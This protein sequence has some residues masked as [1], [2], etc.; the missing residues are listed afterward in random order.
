MF[1][2][3]PRNRAAFQVY[4][5]RAG[6]S[7]QL[8]LARRIGHHGRAGQQRMFGQ[9]AKALRQRGIGGKAFVAGQYGGRHK[10]I[11]RT[12]R[13]VEA[14]SQSEADQG[15]GAEGNQ[16]FRGARCPRRRAASSL[17]Q[18]AKPR[19]NPSLGCQSDDEARAVQKPNSTRR[20]LPRIRFR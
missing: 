2:G 8:G 16:V 19:G 3:H 12:Q 1:G 20:V 4:G 6:R 9:A 18:A 13:G 15:G 10:K 5:V 14:A 17:N 7:V 11:P